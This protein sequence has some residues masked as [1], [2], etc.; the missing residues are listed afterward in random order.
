[1]Q[2]VYINPTERKK[3]IVEMRGEFSDLRSLIGWP[4]V[5]HFLNDCILFTQKDVNEEVTEGFSLGSLVFQG[6]GLLLPTGKE[7]D[8]HRR[9]MERVHMVTTG[10]IK[11]LL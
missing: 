2:Y 11:K 9:L 6:A 3:E 8:E 7:R 5:G 4:V 10:D 1:M